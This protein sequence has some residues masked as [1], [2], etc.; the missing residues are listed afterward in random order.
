M[1]TQTPNTPKLQAVKSSQPTPASGLPAATSAILLAQ[2]AAV[3]AELDKRA[4]QKLAAQDK[5]AAATEAQEGLASAEQAA[6]GGMTEASG[7]AA[8]AVETASIGAA[9]AAASGGVSPWAIGAGVL[10][11]A[12]VAVAAKS[13]SDDNKST[14]KPAPDA[15]KPPVT[16]PVT[17]DPQP[18]VTPPVTP[19]PK[20]P[21]TP[22]VT[23]DPK[24]PVTPPTTPD[25]KPPT[26]TPKVP[27]EAEGTLAKPVV[28]T[29][30]ETNLKAGSFST[31]LDAKAEGIKIVRILAA[32]NRDDADQRVY[33]EFKAAGGKD[34]TN[35]YEVIKVA[36]PL[37]WAEAD[38]QAKALGGK[39]LVINNKEEAEFLR[40]DLSARIGDSPYDYDSLSNGAWIG[41]RQAPG[42]K[43]VDGGWQWSD[44]TA[45]TPAQW[46]TSGYRL[47][48]NQKLPSDGPT[49]P[50]AENGE[51]DFGAIAFAYDGANKPFKGTMLFDY[52][53]KLDRFVVEYEAYEGPLKLAA[54]DGTKTS[55]VDGQILSREQFGKLSWDSLLNSGGKI[56]FIGVDADNKEVGKQQ[57]VSLAE[58]PAASTP[59][60]PAVADKG[61]YLKADLATLLDDNIQPLI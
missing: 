24:P 42:A 60:A 29:N 27:A 19:D 53:G 7:A 1:T 35:A 45:F 38:A 20:P 25:P 32:E 11:V 47:E 49:S 48:N 23:P 8:P 9:P 55:V 37:S 52:G 41:L 10:G 57:V 3:H 14:P 18:P 5:A 21:V 58:K 61:L 46:E 59:A 16:P 34:Q 6:A 12:G 28:A 54:A 30:Q 33:H 40:A 15:N 2:Q 4:E 44:G 43:A 17:P 22:P 56:S 36:K 31:G 26:D 13:G 51:A 39:L 50:I